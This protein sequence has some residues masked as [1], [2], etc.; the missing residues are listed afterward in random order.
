[1]PNCVDCVLLQYADDSA[2]IVSDKDPIKIGQ[3]LSKNL[4][5]CN[6]WLVDNKLSFHMGKTELILFGTKRKLSK[7]KGYTIECE[8]QTITAT[9]HVKYLGLIIDQH[10][11]GE[12]MAL[13]TI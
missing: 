10:L 12:E 1:M 3:Q 8:G 9:P 4:S 5:S 13:S 11:D 7:W 2:L 6:K